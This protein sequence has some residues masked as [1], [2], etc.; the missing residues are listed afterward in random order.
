M[1]EGEVRFPVEMKGLDTLASAAN[2][3]PS[4]PD[5]SNVRK[6]RNGA[7][8][9]RNGF[10]TYNGTAMP[11]TIRA[12]TGI[13]S[14]ARRDT[15][16]R[17]T[18]VGDQ[19]KLFVCPTSG[20]W[21]TL[22]SSL[23]AAATDY[24]DFAVFNNELICVNGVSTPQISD[25]TAGGT[26]TLA[27]QA[28]T[29]A[30]TAM[31]NTQS[32]T[33]GLHAPTPG[34]LIGATGASVAG[35]FDG[36]VQ[37]NNTAGDTWTTKTRNN[38]QR[39]EA[40]GFMVGG[41]VY[42]ASGTSASST[43]TATTE[44][45]SPL[46]D[47]WRG[48]TNITTSLRQATGN[49]AADGTSGLIQCGNDAAGAAGWVATNYLYSSLT[50]SW[51]TKT[52]ISSTARRWASGGSVSGTAHVV[53]G[54]TTVGP[55]NN[56]T[57]HDEYNS[58]ADAW[59]SLAALTAARRQAGGSGA[60]DNLVYV[61]GGFDTTVTAV[62]TIYSYNRVT[63][64]WATS[65]AALG[66]AR[67]IPGVAPDD[68]WIYV[69]G[70]A[71]GANA[72]GVVERYNVSPAAPVAFYVDTVRGYVILARTASFPSRIFY[73]LAGNSRQWA[74]N[75]YIDVNP[76]DGDWIT[77]LFVYRNELYVSKRGIMY[78]IPFTRLDPVLGD[79]EVAPLPEI[80]GTLSNRSIVVTDSGVY[81]FAEDGFRRFDGAQ[82]TMISARVNPTLDGYVA[83]REKYVAGVWVSG[84][85]EIWWSMTASGSTHNRIVVY[86]TRFDE[87]YI[88]TGIN[89]EAIAIV[90]D[91]NDI[92]QI[93]F[94]TGSAS[95]GTVYTAD[96][97][98]ADNTAAID[99]YY[100]TGWF[101][102]VSG[103]RE[104]A[105]SQVYLWA[106]RSG[107]WVLTTD[108]R[109]LYGTANVQTESVNLL[110]GTYGDQGDNYFQDATELRARVPCGPDWNGY[111]L[112]VRLSNAG[113]S[114][115]FEVYA[116]V[117]VGGSGTVGGY[118]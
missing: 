110:S 4:S 96:S 56:V 45:Y 102:P 43:F 7:I 69:A 112:S 63:N 89:A 74:P 66:T 65:A 55:D 35:S 67:V 94:G 105:P 101:S 88:W 14:F 64:A 108:F 31:T 3:Y 51:A 39:D 10:T 12:I 100:Q 73:S 98:T 38:I 116:L 99:A 17:Y 28:A 104:F 75:S 97:T 72:S 114:Q 93:L 23:G 71:V 29:Q 19:E 18:I 16:T 91:T 25:G 11:A 118:P 13:A 79:Q 106:K 103:L 22:A 40:M 59:T 53:S 111:A 36:I 37:S 58:F 1:P 57:T 30:R 68:W 83:S 82:S 47:S 62:T 87:W 46:T 44:A 76:D 70:G 113:A 32:L 84:R 48:V 90:E 117:A 85:D 92:D 20:A 27:N 49:A 61:V 81:Y 50:D 26:G 80:P 115:D 107:N 2:V 9:K 15:T 109:R 78:R 54:R 21:T 24:W 95:D 41:K 77:G 5:L 52:A 60:R 8:A 42:I 33:A 6:L 34:T 86:N